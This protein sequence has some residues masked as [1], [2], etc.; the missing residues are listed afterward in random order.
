MT[1]NSK[2][3]Y[4]ILLTLT[5]S[6]FFSHHAM[7]IPPVG[8]RCNEM[9]LSDA[10]KFNVTPVNETAH[11]E[12]KKYKFEYTFGF[13][14]GHKSPMTYYPQRKVI[15]Q[16]VLQHWPKRITQ[17]V[18]RSKG[19]F[20]TYSFTARRSLFEGQLV[21]DESVRLSYEID[22]IMMKN[23]SVMKPAMAMGAYSGLREITWKD[24]CQ[25]ESSGWCLADSAF[26]F[27]W[28]L[29]EGETI[30]SEQKNIEQAIAPQI[31]QES[32][33]R[34]AEFMYHVANEDKKK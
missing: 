10:Y 27:V 1:I 4:A 31:F 26:S 2:R 28:E 9:S 17:V 21:Y 8:I 3:N 30:E 12:V 11:R 20:V 14:C 22:Y 25:Q 24:E 6:I 5:S 7:T 15:E 32:Y 16:L 19:D 33:R 23:S 13:L 34:Y 18:K 29:K